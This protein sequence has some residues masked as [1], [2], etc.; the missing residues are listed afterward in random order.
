MRGLRLINKTL[1]IL[2]F[3]EEISM[4]KCCVK[5]WKE[6]FHISDQ[7]LCHTT[8]WVL[9]QLE[10][11]MRVPRFQGNWPQF[12]L[13]DILGIRND[14]GSRSVHHKTPVIHILDECLLL[15]KAILAV[16]C[17][18]IDFMCFIMRVICVFLQPRLGGSQ[19]DRQSG[20][21]QAPPGGGLL[22]CG[23]REKSQRHQLLA[24]QVGGAE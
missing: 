15:D 10:D 4:G 8:Q 13:F 23:L 12:N 1:K 18:F 24:E 2:D 14:Q 19:D 9:R 17:I 11:T 5:K 22:W 6:T 16:L 7:H 21:V 3:V 20:T